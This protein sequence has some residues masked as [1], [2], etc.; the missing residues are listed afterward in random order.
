MEL[1]EKGLYVELGAFKYHVFIDFREVR[2]NQWHHYAQLNHNLNGR[3]VA[4]IEEAR[5]EMLLKPLQD[6]FKELVPP[7]MFRKLLEVC[8]TRPDVKLDRQILDEIEQKS[9]NLLKEA[10]WLSGGEKDELAIAR[11]IMRKLEA[12]LRLPSESRRRAWAKDV[13]KKLAE[14]ISTWGTLL[15]WLFVHALGQVV[16]QKDFAE[17][18]CSWIDEWRLGKTIASVLMDLGQKEAAAWRSVIVIKLLTHHQHW[19]ELPASAQNQPH[20]VL[21]SLLKDHEVNQFLKVN[22]F[23]DILWFNK[24]AF[25]ELRGWLLQVAIVD[26]ISDPLRSPSKRMKEIERCHR[27]VLKWKEAEKRSEYQV[28]KLLEALKE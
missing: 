22:R 23:N 12:T 1:C 24:E 18:S 27:I 28:G 16:T 9:I 13:Q 6:A 20:H 2:D 7:S 4:N 19:F 25:D 14:G 26:I 8:A 21:E 10:K 17:R 3:G 5:E 11:E 15:S